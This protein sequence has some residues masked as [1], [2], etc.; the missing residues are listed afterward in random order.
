MQLGD[1]SLGVQGN[2]LPSSEPH[3]NRP[4]PLTR[5]APSRSE[6]IVASERGR[7]V[8]SAMSPSTAAPPP[9]VTPKR[10]HE[11]R[12]EADAKPTT[13][14]ERAADTA[15]DLA[16]GMLLSINYTRS[17]I[18][19]RPRNCMLGC[20]A[21]F[22]VVFFTGLVLASIS[23][24]S[25]MLLRF[26]ELSIGEMDAVVYATDGIPFVN[27]TDVST[28][29]AANASSVVS[30][31]A[32]RWLAKGTLRKWAKNN[33]SAAGAASLPMNILIA[34]TATET[35]LGIGRGWPYRQIGYA[36]V[37]VTETALEYLSLLSNI[38]E[39]S[40]LTID[41]ERLL[42]QQTF[43][44][45]ETI[46]TPTTTANLTDGQISFLDQL[47]DLASNTSGITI[48]PANNTEIEI[49][50]VPISVPSLLSPRVDLTV[51]DGIEKPVGKY[52]TALGNTM[53][54][55][56]KQFLQLLLDQSCASGSSVFSTSGNAAID[57][58]TNPLSALGVT[59]LVQDVNPTDYTLLM[60]AMFRGRFET[61]YKSSLALVKDMIRN[62]NA[63]ML[64]ID[65]RYKG[66]VVYPLAV[67]M[68]G[69]SQF[70]AIL[71]SIFTT[72]VIV[73]VVIGAILVYS[74]LGTNGEERQYELAMIRALGMN[75]MQLLS[76]MT[77]EVLAFTIPGVT[78]GVLL[79]LAAN[80]VLEKVLSDFTLTPYDGWRIPVAT[81]VVA[82]VIG[83]VLP[84]VS[85]WTPVSESFNA[86][87]RDALDVN[88]Q[89]WSET[90]VTMIKLAEL[91]LE[92]W[93][94]LLG[95]FLVVSGFVIYYLVPL[96]FIFGRIEL[97]FTIMNL[98]LLTMLFGLCML[99]YTLQHYTLTFWLW[100]MLW[101]K[102]KRLRTLITKNF[103]AHRDK[104]TRA[105][106][107]F[108]ICV[109]CVIFGGIA[110]DMLSNTLVALIEMAAGADFFVTSTR[111]ATPLNRTALDAFL[112][113][114]QGVY[115][116]S[117][118]YATFELTQYPQIMSG[119]TL[120]NILGTSTAVPLLAVTER[121]LDTVIPRYVGIH[122]SS[123]AYPYNTSSTGVQDVVRSL[124]AN[125]TAL[126]SG[127]PEIVYSGYPENLQRPDATEKMRQVIPILVGSSLE[128]V[129][130]LTP[131]TV[132]AVEY[133]YNLN[134]GVTQTTDF[135]V[136]PRALL[137]RLSGFPTISSQRLFRGVALVSTDAFAVL[138]QA[139]STDFAS[140]DGS[141]TSLPPD[142][143]LEP[144]F[145]NL[146]IRVKPGL[147]SSQQAFFLNSLQAN[148]DPFFSTAVNTFDTVESI[149]QIAVLINAFYYFTAGIS[150]LLASFMVWLVFVSNVTQ[151]AWSFG[152]LRSLGFTK[153][154]L[155]RTSIY[156]ALSI[157]LSSITIGVPIGL[158]IGFT[159]GLQLNTFMNL[160]Y[161]FEFPYPV[162]LILI[163]ISLLAATLGSY[164]PLASLNRLCIAAVLKKYN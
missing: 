113:A 37:Q 61:Y 25:Y 109:S 40:S 58:I 72:V 33:E 5:T 143:V 145:K 94:T 50:S 116:E 123:S 26:A 156:E 125:P 4:A 157:V 9:Y 154:Q 2:V 136:V 15:T 46:D 73:I 93:Q 77:T 159:A 16:A 80:A 141:T 67:A 98:I 142:A 135:L 107:I 70:G 38:G 3:K 41:L 88:R 18:R 100:C 1:A 28:K 117:W 118:A 155:L 106:M 7:D 112:T 20:C 139:N 14:C 32:P 148:L 140:L 13:A 133:N 10:Q 86:S 149:Q 95:A 45:P 128:P 132:A 74:L 121:F 69:F 63:M 55:D 76:V 138:L 75:K 163:G 8:S 103:E 47:L 144:R 110:F 52:P 79:L 17:D 160:P 43:V 150:V 99:G 21:V 105:F 108:V 36:E 27:F 44:I 89:A 54:L 81:T 66:E 102:E 111:F 53:V 12:S 122:S 83:F 64:A 119:V 97:F 161:A 6:N 34:D 60:V 114:N 39:R 151:H 56:Y 96:S 115:V 35:S 124:Y 91:G 162:L 104:N 101:G 62:S 71:T 23:K 84:I 158:F 48:A 49:P 134:S 120:K 153:A 65:Y 146:Y 31:S 85:N 126:R 82:V 22:L 152:V 24:T 42:Q 90:K 59:T 68:E 29:L 57:A 164:A 92:M 129:L 11:V 137:N 147:S 131:S 78:C 30:G 127:E 87:L 19:S 51:A 130:G